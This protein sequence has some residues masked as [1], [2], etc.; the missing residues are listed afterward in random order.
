MRVRETLTVALWAVN[1]AEAPASIADVAGQI[2]ARMAEAR[3]AGADLLVLP[4]YVSEP[5][6]TL[7]PRPL[8]GTEEVAFMAERGAELLQLLRPLPE[9]H[10]LALLPG[11][12]PVRAQRRWLNRAHLLLP[13][14]RLVS[15]DKLCLTPSEREPEGWLLGT[16]GEVRIVE[17]AGLRLAVVICLDIELPAL[18]ARLQ[19][20]DLDL[21]LVPSMTRLASGQARVSAC[22]RARA[23][24]LMTAVCVVGCIGATPLD[25]PRPNTGGAAAYLPCEP[26]LEP[27]GVAVELTARSHVIGP[28]PLILARD[29]PIGEIRLR[30]HGDAEVWPGPW[31]ADHLRIVKS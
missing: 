18:A 3:A 20:A 16:G 28:G 8:H 4:E 24:E 9:R 6:L 7:A 21:V 10:G 19:G 27:M 12:W 23:V 30:R 1:M 26:G 5:W 15:Q 2:E 13:D 31:S 25:P 29:L 14:G 11:T 22:A 17:W